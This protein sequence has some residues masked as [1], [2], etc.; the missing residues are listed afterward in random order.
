MKLRVDRLGSWLAAL[1]FVL[2]LLFVPVSVFAQT[3]SDVGALHLT[4]L[5]LPVNVVGKPGETVTTTLRIKNSGSKTEVLKVGLLKFSAYGQDGKPQLL[6][7]EKG[8]DYFDWVRFSQNKFSA[9]PD[10]WHEITMTIALPK[11]AALGYYYAVTFSRLN[12][13]TASNTNKLLGGTA[14]LVLV[15][16]QSPNAK[17]EIAID[18]FIALKRIYEFLPAEFTIKLANKGNIH[19][20][21]TGNIFIKQGGRVITTLDVNQTAGNILPNTKRI[22]SAQWSDGF[23]VYTAVES[24]GKTQ[25]DKKGNAVY[26]L[27]WDISKISHLRFGYYT[28]NLVMTYDDGKRDVPLEAIVGFWVIPWRLIAATIVP[29]VLVGFLIYKY[30]KLRKRLKKL[31]ARVAE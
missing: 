11:D 14:I 25:L 16:A 9:E 22:F 31:T 5:P 20:A 15:E 18:Q 29:L 21:S 2:A 1:A 3:S 23:P 7:R 26:K 27:K 10:V 6:D 8:D 17:R 4:N 28:A 30:L 12:P 24:G 13:P 19:L